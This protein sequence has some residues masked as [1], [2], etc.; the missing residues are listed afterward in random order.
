MNNEDDINV[1]Y[2]H[3]RKCEKHWLLFALVQFI[4][5]FV[6]VFVKYSKPN[7]T[8]EI[9]DEMKNN[10]VKQPNIQYTVECFVC[11]QAGA[12][13]VTVSAGLLQRTF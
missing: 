7:E 5:V 10:T 9:H 12:Q 2:C 1:V 6:I 13:P 4:S 11:T 8:R 3:L